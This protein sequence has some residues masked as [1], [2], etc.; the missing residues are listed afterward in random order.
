MDPRSETAC[1]DLECGCDFQCEMGPRR[2]DVPENGVELALN[3]QF[4]RA[5]TTAW[6]YK[7]KAAAGSHFFLGLE[8]RDHVRPTGSQDG[9][10]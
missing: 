7:S 4:E 6:F 10:S 2:S 5:M 8:E 3:A 9:L 1:V